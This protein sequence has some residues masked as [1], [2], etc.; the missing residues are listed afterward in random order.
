MLLCMGLQQMKVHHGCLLRCDLAAKAAMAELSE[1]GFIKPES[2]EIS[3][4]QYRGQ[5]LL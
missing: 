5:E 1:D 3:G 4:F 2:A